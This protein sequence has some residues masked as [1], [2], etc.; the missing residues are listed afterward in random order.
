M[1]QINVGVDLNVPLT[2]GFVTC[3]YS[4]LFLSMTQYFSTL[5]L[6]Y[7]CLLFVTMIQDVCA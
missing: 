2:L 5:R 7:V 1:P 3:D 4:C 6:P